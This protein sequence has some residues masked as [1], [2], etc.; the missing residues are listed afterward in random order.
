M[1]SEAAIRGF[2][3]YL[4]EKEQNLF[5][6]QLAGKSDTEKLYFVLCCLIFTL[7]IVFPILTLI[8]T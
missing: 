2:V 3:L 8:L 5:K 4:G 1:R 7:H 6:E